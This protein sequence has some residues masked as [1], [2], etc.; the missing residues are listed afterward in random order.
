MKR[1]FLMNLVIFLFWIADKAFG[2]A[3]R[4]ALKHFNMSFIN[5][6]PDEPHGEVVRIPFKGWIQ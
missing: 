5:V 1:V 4:I 6:P 3:T 2:L